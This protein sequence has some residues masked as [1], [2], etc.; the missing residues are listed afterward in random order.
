[1]AARLPTI[2]SNMAGRAFLN[3]AGLSAAGAAAPS[4]VIIV[5]EFLMA[6]GALAQIDTF[7]VVKPLGAKAGD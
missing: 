5:M 1:M 6:G 4:W 3:I 2:S 7:Q